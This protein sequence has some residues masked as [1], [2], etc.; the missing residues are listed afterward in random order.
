MRDI[1]FH[2]IDEATKAQRSDSFIII[3]LGNNR[4]R[5]KPGFLTSK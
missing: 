5:T 3:Y 4:P 2:F 1:Y